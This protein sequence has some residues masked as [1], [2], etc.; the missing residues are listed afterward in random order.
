M[1]RIE[2]DIAKRRLGFFFPEPIGAGKSDKQFLFDW[3][4][5]ES[6]GKSIM[7]FLWVDR[8]A[9]FLLRGVDMPVV[10]DEWRTFW[11]RF[12]LSDNPPLF[13]GDSHMWAGHEVVATQGDWEE[14][15]SFDAHHDLGYN[16]KEFETSPGQYSV[17]CENWLRFYAEVVGAMTTVVYPDWKI[18]AFALEESFDAKSSVICRMFN[19]KF[20]RRLKPD[21]VFVARSGTWVPPWCDKQFKDFVRMYPGD[22]DPYV[23]D[24]L[25]NREEMWD[26][27]FDIADA[28]KFKTHLEAV[29]NV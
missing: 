3:G 15:V 4:F 12:D 16:G 9:T 17:T 6:N 7:D 28:E 21:L 27:T 13:V 20:N 11:D 18:K 10:N 22:K 26:R 1:D 24:L 23:F 25:H 5:S 8:A 14:V 29:M 19:A 2:N